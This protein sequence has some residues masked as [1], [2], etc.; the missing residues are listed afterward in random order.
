MTKKNNSD[1]LLKLIDNTTEIQARMNL[2]SDYIRRLVDELQELSTGNIGDDL[3]DLLSLAVREMT[4]EVNALNNE[5]GKA[6]E[7]REVVNNE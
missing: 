6:D 1:I 2:F 3:I 4:G 7:D 5:I